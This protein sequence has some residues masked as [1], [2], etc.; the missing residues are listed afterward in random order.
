MIMIQEAMEN[1]DKGR[2][3]IM[4]CFDTLGQSEKESM[5]KELKNLA[6]QD[7]YLINLTQRLEDTKQTIANLTAEHARKI[8]KTKKNASY[9][10]NGLYLEE[11]LK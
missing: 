10:K 11:T 6:S 2:N 8:A 7:S 4:Q 3:E 9:I 1:E 5:K